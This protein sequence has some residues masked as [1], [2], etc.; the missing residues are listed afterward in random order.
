MKTD[1]I[2]YDICRRPVQL[3][4]NKCNCYNKTCWDC[5]HRVVEKCNLHDYT[6]YSDPIPCDDF[7]KT[8]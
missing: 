1:C 5:K 4:N 7:E 6:L 2:N 8:V 3:C